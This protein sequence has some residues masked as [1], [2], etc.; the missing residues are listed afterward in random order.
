MSSQHSAAP[1]IAVTLQE[2]VALRDTLRRAPGHVVARAGAHVSRQRSRGMEFAETRPWLPGD[3]A[4]AI[5][6]RQTARRGTAWTKLFQEERQ[7]PLLLLADLGAAMRFGTRVAFKSVAAA[8]AAA[9]LA[10]SAARAGDPVGGVVCNGAAQI[11]IPP[12]SREQGALQLLQALAA[13]S[14]DSAGATA[15]LPLQAL[16]PM[17]RPSCTAIVISDFAMLDTG[18]EH[19]ITRLAAQAGLCLLQVHDVFETEAV[20]PGIYR[21]TDGVRRATLDLRSAAARTAYGAAF[22]ARRAALERLA[23]RVRAQLLPLATHEDAAAVLAMNG[24]AR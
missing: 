24:M 4:R 11:A 5:D 20:P 3:D 13:T 12:R 8:R 2:L 7:R 22:A 23:R 21:V 10:W 1:G 15:G 16:T 17:L 9:L 19:A 18:L 6:W 14:A